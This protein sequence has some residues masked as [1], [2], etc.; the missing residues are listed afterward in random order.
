MLAG[1][2]VQSISVGFDPNWYFDDVDG[3]T[4]GVGEIHGGGGF[5][6]YDFTTSTEHDFLASGAGEAYAF[7]NGDGQYF[8]WQDDYAYLIDKSAW[9]VTAGPVATNAWAGADRPM[10]IGVRQGSGKVWLGFSQ[11]ST[12]DLSLLQSFSSGDW[13][14]A[15]SA[16]EPVYDAINDALWTRGTLDSAITVRYLD[17]AVQ[18]WRH[19]RDHHLRD[20]HRR[21]PRGPRHV[22][23]D[24]DG[25]RLFVDR[26]DVKSQMEPLLDIHDVDACPHD[27]TLKFLPRGSSSAGTIVTADF[28]KN[29]EGPR[30]KTTQQQDT[31][32]PKLLR[33]NF[34]DTGF[35]QQTNNIL[36]PLPVDV[37]DS[38][39]DIVIDLTTS[40]DT[41]TGAQQK[42]D[43][44]MRRVWNGR[45]TVELSLTARYRDI[46]PG[47][48]M[49]LDLDG[50]QWNAKLEKQTF[51][52]GRMDCTF[53]RDETALA[54][55]NSSTTGPEMGARDPET[56]VI[57]P[58][59]QGVRDRRALSRGQRRGHQA[60]AL[61][62]G[63]LLRR[64]WPSPAQRSGR[65]PVSAPARP[66]I[67]SSR[68]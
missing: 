56:I 16:Q 39:N 53:R 11:Y 68:R 37:V 50:I 36:S 64:S 47:V 12:A 5:A 61:F 51:V 65:R 2:V 34:S 27:F 45:D 24:A 14:A 66:S 9:T 41:P 40:A 23:P 7:D 13:G 57:P 8:V 1:N 46:E 43:R 26:G 33:V 29:G 17:R 10:F 67:N 58:P 38:Q 19:A 20:V 59:D 3:K 21:R 42:G 55:L 6:L 48:V 63:G 44:Y 31:D 35:D 60:P 28:A 4:I 22:A 52:G 49:T 30:Y 54:T 32:L 18:C 25:A 62:G 15:S